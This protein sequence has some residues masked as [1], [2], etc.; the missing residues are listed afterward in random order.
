MTHAGGGTQVVVKQR[1]NGG[2]WH[3]LGA[4]KLKPGQAHGVDLESSATG[5]VAAGAIRIVTDTTTS[6][7]VAYVHVDSLATPQ[8][9]TGPIG[10]AMAIGPLDLDHG[11]L[12]RP[13]KAGAPW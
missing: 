3:L 11:D 13:G 7:T 8:I 9:I 4:F 12:A 6:Q 10:P 1:R 2:Q 5:L